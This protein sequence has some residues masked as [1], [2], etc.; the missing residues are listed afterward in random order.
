VIGGFF[1]PIQQNKLCDAGLTLVCFPDNEV[2]GT[3]GECCVAGEQKPKRFCFIG[4]VGKHK[5]KHRITPGL[6]I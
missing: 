5:K 2:Y 1:Q 4:E 6:V 3:E